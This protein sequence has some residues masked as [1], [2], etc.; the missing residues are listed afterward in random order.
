MP[1]RIFSSH[2]PNPISVNYGSVADPHQGAGSEPITHFFRDLDPPMCQND[3]LRLPPSHLWCG[4]G[5]SFPKWCGPIRIRIRNTS[6]NLVVV[7][8][9]KYG[10]RLPVEATWFYLGAVLIGKTWSVKIMTLPDN[11]LMK[12]SFL[13]LNGSVR[14]QC[15]CQYR[16]FALIFSYINYCFLHKG[17]GW[18]S[19]L[20]Y[21]SD[22]KGNLF[23]LLMIF[24]MEVTNYHNLSSKYT[25]LSL[26]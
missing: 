14:C 8:L 2:P 3:P 19:R 4:S 24:I 21:D 25:F 18:W 1:K 7:S 5:S 16:L 12:C 22:Q 11:F 10:T 20:E 15:R 23:F 6:V 17:G 26:L 9:F 13:Q